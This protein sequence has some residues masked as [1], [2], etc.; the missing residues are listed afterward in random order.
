M[1]F[2]FSIEQSDLAWLVDACHVSRV[3]VCVV[4]ATD[5]TL[6]KCSVAVKAAAAVAEAMGN[7]VSSGS[8]VRSAAKSSNKTAAALTTDIP[9]AEAQ[10]SSVVP[11]YDVFLSH[12]QVAC[13]YVTTLCILICLYSRKIVFC[14]DLIRDEINPKISQ[15]P[16]SGGCARLLHVA[17]RPPD[18]E[19][20]RKSTRLN[21][22]H[23]IG[24]RM[25]SS[26]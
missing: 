25:P 1:K 16:S 21:S 6:L 20:D 23:Y 9:A 12:R 11:L 24:S 5:A 26:A 15:N 10:L 18:F 3:V 7:R 4:C 8:G 14:L 2:V 19:R 17:V 22:S 13:A